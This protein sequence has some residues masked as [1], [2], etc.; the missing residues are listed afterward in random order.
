MSIKRS[1]TINWKSKISF[2]CR[3]CFNFWIHFLHVF[4]EHWQ[5]NLLGIAS[6]VLP[7]FIS[8]DMPRYSYLLSRLKSS[9][10]SHFISFF[11]QVNKYSHIIVIYF[12]GLISSI[13]EKPFV[14]TVS[15]LIGDSKAFK[16][17]HSGSV[18][19]FV[20]LCRQMYP[21]FENKL[22]FIIFCWEI[23]FSDI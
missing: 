12:N 20:F 11:I 18:N 8:R 23:P 1:R 16:A 22:S 17:L 15:Y 10:I 4:L 3:N 7:S 14:G 19:F 13:N 9:L 5:T 21:F 6:R 2:P